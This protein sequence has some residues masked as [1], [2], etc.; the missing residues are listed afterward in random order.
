MSHPRKSVSQ[1]ATTH[2]ITIRQI[3]QATNNLDKIA[4]DDDFFCQLSS[5][6]NCVS[7]VM[8]YGRCYRPQLAVQLRSFADYIDRL[9][10]NDPE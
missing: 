7:R 4:K 8:T 2:S 10:V 1:F 5:L 3:Q 6:L 9:I